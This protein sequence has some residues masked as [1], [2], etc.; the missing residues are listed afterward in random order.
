[1]IKKNRP[2]KPFCRLYI[3][4]AIFEEA[5]RILRELNLELRDVVAMLCNQIVLHRK[6]PFEMKAK[7]EEQKQACD[8]SGEK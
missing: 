7:E 1:M 2:R 8:N 5:E 3:D 6:L 4:E